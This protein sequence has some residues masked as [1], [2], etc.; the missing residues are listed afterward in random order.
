MRLVD[1]L[2]PDPLESSQRFPSPLDGFHGGG[3]RKGEEERARK[4][5]E[6][7]PNVWSALTALNDH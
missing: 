3:G 7:T 2:R 4:E 5:R 1:G 6:R